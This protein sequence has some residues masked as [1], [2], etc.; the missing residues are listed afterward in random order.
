MAGIAGINKP[1][2]IDVVNNLLSKISHRGKAKKIVFSTRFSTLGAVT[3]NLES[4]NTENFLKENCVRDYFG[5]EHFAEAKEINGSLELKRD[6]IGVAPLYYGYTNE[7]SLIF[8]SE[9]KSLLE[10]T[11][12]IKEL[13]P[14]HYLINNKPIQYYKYE[15]PDSYFNGNINLIAEQLYSLLN[16]SIKRRIKNK[17]LGCW[18]SGGLDSSI[19]S[20]LVRPYVDKL[21][22]FSIG[23]KNSS[24]LE[25]S[26]IMAKYLN[27]IHHE[28]QLN[29]E[30]MI[31]VLPDVIYHLESFDAFLVRSSITNFLLSKE[32]S[33]YVEHVFSGEGGDELFGGYSYLK[34]ISPMQLENELIDI[35]NRLHNTALQRVDR[36]AS[37]FSTI[38]SVVFVDPSVVNFSLRIPSKYKI[39]D[40]T[41]KWILRFAMKDRLPE[42]ISKRRKAKFWEGAGNGKLL[43]EY[44]NAK[45]SDSDFNQERV[46][47]NGYVL[48]SK[49]ELMYYRIFKEHFGELEDLDWMGRTKIV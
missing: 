28:I 42:E 14:G 7:G 39:Y 1:G 17:E 29:F 2:Q 15:K 20:S 41:E 30:Q 33:N 27:S 13:L 21:H 37:A 6:A 34:K 5:D 19:I 46:L 36:C 4:V 11:K 10:I 32:V 12:E 45:I 9:I 38:A 49:E 24:D 3:N 31:N 44:A 40:G 48:N 47:K 18:L 35:T 43:F 16:D 26:R 25:Y 23:F 8:A 22:T